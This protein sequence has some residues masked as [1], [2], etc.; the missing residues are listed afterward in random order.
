VTFGSI[1]TS[2]IPINEFH[3]IS[4]II[5]P[6]IEIIRAN[7]LIDMTAPFGALEY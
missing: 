4:I 5:L 1:H 3:N 6:L 7:M 2:E